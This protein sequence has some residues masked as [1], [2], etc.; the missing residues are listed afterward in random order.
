M[1][2]NLRQIRESKKI[3]QSKLARLTGVSRQALHAIEKEI[4]EPSLQLAM[5]IAEALE[6]SIHAIFSE[7]ED[8]TLKISEKTLSAF[9]RL[10]LVNQYRILQE[11]HPEEDYLKAHYK[12][13]E[14]IFERGYVHLYYEAFD[15]I[16]E[17]LPKEI[18]D[19]TLEILAL[20]RAM[21]WS[22]GQIPDPKDLE[23]VKF[24]GFDANH[25]GEYLGFAQFFCSDG[26]NYQE[27]NIYNSHHPTLERYRK[28]LAE[29]HRMGANHR[30]S[31]EQIDSILDAGTFRH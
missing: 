21:L 16:R 11:L 5:K 3:T 24:Y 25:E 9:D 6:T 23:R 10:H 17:E 13:L 30:L 31:K 20:H 29:W 15:Q 27:L 19:E 8:M 12:R 18:S 28:M 26:D 7:K 22:L 4:H 1:P 2:N 14:E